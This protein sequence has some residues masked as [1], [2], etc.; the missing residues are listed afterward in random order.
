MELDGNPTS[1]QELEIKRR[2]TGQSLSNASVLSP[3]E[4]EEMLIREF[5]EG[6]KDIEGGRLRE[7]GLPYLFDAFIKK[8]VE[9]IRQPK[10][11]CSILISFSFDFQNRLFKFSKALLITL[12]CARN[13]R[14]CWRIVVKTPRS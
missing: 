2:S 9:R 13:A 7:V 12:V 3:G 14:R 8:K 6:E 1:P 4:E 5:E 10:I 11:S